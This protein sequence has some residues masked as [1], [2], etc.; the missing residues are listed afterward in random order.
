MF[1]QY[2]YQGP[3]YLD[4]KNAA[5]TTGLSVYFLRQGIKSGSIETVKCGVKYYIN[6]PRLLERLNSA[7]NDRR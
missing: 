5:K 7:P 3:L 2:E 4:I 6:V 1:S